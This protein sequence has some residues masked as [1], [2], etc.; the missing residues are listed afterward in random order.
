MKYRAITISG[1]I[2]TGKSSL[3][4]E[5]VKKLGWK[6]YSS[7]QFFR[8]WCLK[9]NL[10]IFAAHLRPES[11]TREIDEGAK[12]KLLDEKNIIIEGWL[13][14]FVAQKIPGVLKVLLTCDLEMRIKRFSQ[15]ENVDITCARREIEKREGNLFEK[16]QKVYGRSDFFDPKF[17][18]LVIDAT[19][20]K[21]KEILDLVLQKL[22]EWDMSRN[23][24]PVTVDGLIIKEG[25]ILLVKRNHEPYFGFWAIPGGYVEWEETCEEAVVREVKEETGLRTRI[26]RMIGVYSGPSRSPSYT[27]TVAYLMEILGGKVEKSYEATEIDWFSLNDLPT[28]AFDHKEIIDDFLKEV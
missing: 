15:R 4:T 22:E 8:D 14:G 25:K 9:H 19:N 10:P 20:L 17:Y 26:K 18:D 21:P 2:C 27:I 7:S 1:K 23:T 24:R 3:F 6:S 12:E 5:L 13:A 11:L 28:L 16:W